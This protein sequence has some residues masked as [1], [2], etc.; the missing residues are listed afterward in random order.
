MTTRL[1]RVLVVEDHPV[2][3]DG[4]AAAFAGCDDVV[5][6]AAVGTIAE[7]CAAAATERPTVILLDLG[8]PDG[9]GLSAVPRLLR[10][11]PRPALLVLTMNDDRDVVLDA[12]R[13]GAHGFLLK[14]AGR[15]EVVDAV[16][17]AAAGG[18]VF[19][20]GA[21]QVVMAAAARGRRDPADELGLTRRE[22]EVLRLVTAGL[23]NAAIAVR[24]GVSPKTVR[25]QV[26]AVLT[27]LG[28]TSRTEAADRARRAGM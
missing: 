7:A 25:N 13:A 15:L 19:S 18:A 22:S 24:L 2:Y 20:P 12:V 6:A 3:R 10:G 17:R 11:D 27:K 14:G 28:V 8:L 5:V 23:G 21:A 9:D 4:L 1:I 26:S 16:R